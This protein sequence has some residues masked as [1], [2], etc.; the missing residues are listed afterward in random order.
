[1]PIGIGISDESSTGTASI[2]APL[3]AQRLDRLLAA[4]VDR[5]ITVI[6]WVPLAIYQGIFPPGPRPHG[7]KT[8]AA[9]TIWSHARGS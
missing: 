5:V 1:V 9:F 6:F 7:L 3:L 4:V 2:D 8:D